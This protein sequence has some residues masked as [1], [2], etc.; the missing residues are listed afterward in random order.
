MNKDVDSFLNYL[1]VEK[2]FSGNTIAAYHNDLYQLLEFVEGQAPRM[3]KT[4]SWAIVNRSLLLSYILNLKQRNYSST[5]VARKT[6]AVKSLMHFLFAEK[7]IK[8]DPTENLGA[9]KVSKS[10]P[11]P[12][13]IYE[14]RQLLEQPTK[15][16][17]R[18]AKRDK[19]MLEMLYASGMRV[20]ELVSLNIEDMNFDEGT[21]RCRGKGDKERLLPIHQQAINYLKEY[22]DKV[23]PKMVYGDKEKAMF[24]NRRGDRLTRQGL[25]QILK[26]YA[27]K[28]NLGT[29]ITPHT[30]RHSFATHLL[31][32]GADLRSVQELLGHSNISTT[33]IYTHIT[34]EHMRKAYDASHPR[35]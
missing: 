21:I 7:I 33:Q 19:A 5:T 17:S 15:S 3:G 16:R 20:S 24:V 9:P 34:S 28:A 13:S 10:L 26:N 25:W 1:L 8:V 23:R 35:A 11:K 14:V 6:A 27:L 30:L 22:L 29:K 31:N 4:P 18:E 32:G 12:L 2:G